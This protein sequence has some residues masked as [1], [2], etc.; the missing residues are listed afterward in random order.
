MAINKKLIHFKKEA[1][2]K[3]ELDSGNILQTS[4]VFIQDTKKI[5]THGQYYN[6]DDSTILEKINSLTKN[7]VGLGNVDNTSDTNKPVSTAQA[8]AIKVVQDD[9]TSHKNNETNPHKVTKSQVGLGNVD[10]TSDLDKPISTATQ[11]ALTQ[12]DQN[13]TQETKERI[14]ADDTKVDKIA[15]KGLSTNDF[16]DEYKGILD[17]PWGITIK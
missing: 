4:I 13:L 9:L 16:T 11:N 1:S 10:N 5:W 6:C 2:F 17:N 7:D 12:I 14:S 8:A 3:P 15:G